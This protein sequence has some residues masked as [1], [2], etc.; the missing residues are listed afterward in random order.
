MR[1]GQE[2]VGGGTGQGVNQLQVIQKRCI[3]HARGG[4][5]GLV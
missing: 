4:L 1:E 3:V 2:A 5:E